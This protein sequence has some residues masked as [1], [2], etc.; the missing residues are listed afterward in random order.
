MISDS[1]IF[2]RLIITRFGTIVEEWFSQQTLRLAADLQFDETTKRI[3]DNSTC[4]Y[5]PLTH[6]FS[7]EIIDD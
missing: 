7:S 3:N 2:A 6:L 4:G 5:A 1:K